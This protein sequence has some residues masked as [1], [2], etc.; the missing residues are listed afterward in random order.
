MLKLVIGTWLGVG[1]GDAGRLFSLKKN[2]SEVTFQWVAESG[3]SCEGQGH[4]GDPAG[5]TPRVPE[6]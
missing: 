6:S 5:Q 1:G 4:H 2:Y 3:W